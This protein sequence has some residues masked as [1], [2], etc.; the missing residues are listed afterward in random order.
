MALIPPAMKVSF[1]T[2]LDCFLS[3]I[4]DTINNENVKDNIQ[5]KVLA[6]IKNVN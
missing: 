2:Y 1:N 5:N 6:W 3:E 4:L